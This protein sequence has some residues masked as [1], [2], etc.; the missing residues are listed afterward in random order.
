MMLLVLLILLI[1]AGWL[2]DTVIDNV[3]SRLKAD[4]RRDGSFAI[5]IIN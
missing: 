2:V 4:N 5:L 3:E 1:L